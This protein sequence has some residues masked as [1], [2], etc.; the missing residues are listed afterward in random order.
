MDENQT[1][2][3]RTCSTH[4]TYNTTLHTTIHLGCLGCPGCRGCLGTAPIE[5]TGCESGI[6]STQTFQALATVCHPQTQRTSISRVCNA[7]TSE[8]GRSASILSADSGRAALRL[9]MTYLASCS[10]SLTSGLQQDVTLINSTSDVVRRA[11]VDQR[12]LP[13]TRATKSGRWLI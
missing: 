7:T 12:H 3:C 6:S 4:P 5:T 13:L 2:Q 1:L 9:R 10:A 8:R 11:S